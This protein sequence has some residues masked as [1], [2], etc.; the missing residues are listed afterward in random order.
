MSSLIFFIN[1]AFKINH[2]YICWPTFDMRSNILRLI[3]CNCRIWN[4]CPAQRVFGNRCFVT[5][6]QKE[7]AQDTTLLSTFWWLLDHVFRRGRLVPT[8]WAR[9]AIS[10]TDF[11]F[12]GSTRKLA[13]TL[14]PPRF[15]HTL[16]ILVTSKTFQRANGLLF[17]FLEDFLAASC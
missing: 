8:W 14:R 15:R 3:N 17:L 4:A 2:W 13:D 10:M 7:V 5:F 12:I 11:V 1:D 6:G 16:V 9:L